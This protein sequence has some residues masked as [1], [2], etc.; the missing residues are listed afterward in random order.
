MADEALKFSFKLEGK[1]CRDCQGEL[2]SLDDIFNRSDFDKLQKNFRDNMDG[3]EFPAFACSC[4]LIYDKYLNQ[5]TYSLTFL[6]R[7][8]Y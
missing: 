6:K 8:V 3:K 1:F 4:G 2:S 7:L 5:K